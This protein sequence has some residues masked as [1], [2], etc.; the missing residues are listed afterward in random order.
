[1]TK[2]RLDDLIDGI[3]SAHPE[4]PLDQLTNAVLLA[5][6]MTELADHLIG[7]FVDN[8]RHKGASWTE[9]GSCIGVT[10]QAAQQRFTA[11]PDANMF[12]K[13]TPRA[14][15]AVMRS[16]EEARA[17]RLDEIHPEHLVLAM[18]PDAHSM[19]MRALDAQG[20]TAAAIRAAVTVPPG[21]EGFE[22]PPLIKYNAAA[23]KALELTGREAFRLGHNYIGT[24]HML[25]ALLAAEDGTGLL[26]R[27]GVEPGKVEAYILDALAT[28]TA[29]SADG[30]PAPPPPPAPPAPPARPAV[31]PVPPTPSD[32]PPPP[33]PGAPA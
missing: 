14:R 29:G 9:I 32:P 30:P 11:K 3:R 28:I 31:P 20:V 10:K 25:L 27:V 15:E 12:A 2:P 4:S 18:L 26:H 5:E 7:H 13:F 19:A 17:A 6:H 33:R 23:K 1:M 22:P 21:P 24:E 8:A 16:Q